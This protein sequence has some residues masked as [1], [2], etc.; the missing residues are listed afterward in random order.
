[1]AT[2]PSALSARPAG[3]L[4][5]WITGIVNDLGLNEALPSGVGAASIVVAH[6]AP[7]S[8]EQVEAHM[9][10][11]ASINSTGKGRDRKS[12]KVKK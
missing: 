11:A 2:A 12:R 10:K 3:R 9:A 4:R 1:M 8:K 5:S 6:R 7:T